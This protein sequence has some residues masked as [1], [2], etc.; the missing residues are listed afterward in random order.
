[1]KNFFG[2]ILLITCG[3]HLI[4]FSNAQQYVCAYE[5]NIDY[6]SSVDITYVY[7]SAPQFC[8]SLCGLKPGCIGNKLEFCLNNKCLLRDFNSI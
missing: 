2:L 8:C 5:N 7:T 4:E 6:Y 1:M 3:A